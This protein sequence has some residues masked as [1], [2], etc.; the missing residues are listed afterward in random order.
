MF[1]QGTHFDLMDATWDTSARSPRFFRTPAL[2]ERFRL[3]IR[4][5]VTKRITA[6]TVVILVFTQEVAKSGY[7][8]CAGQPSPGRGDV[9]GFDLRALVGCT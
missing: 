8:I 6:G 2:A 5:E 3:G 4:A 1:Q 7:G 9:E